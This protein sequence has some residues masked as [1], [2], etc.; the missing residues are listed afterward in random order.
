MR[1][2]SALVLVLAAACGDDGSPANPDAPTTEDAPPVDAD[3]SPRDITLRFAPKVGDAAFAC[4][5]SY[6]NLGAQ[7]T[8]VSPRDFRFYLHDVKL[9]SATGERVPVTLASNDWQHQGVALL[10]FEDFTGDCEDGTA[11]TNATVTGTAPDGTYTGISFTLG[12]PAALNHMDLTTLP[13]PLNV[14][15]LW[16]SWSSGHLFLAAATHTEITDPE[17]G[18]ND[19]YFHLGSLGCTGDPSMG[20]TVTCAKPNRPLIEVTGFDPLTTPIIAD[21][22]AL[23]PKSN[24]ATEVGC[25]SFTQAPCA[26]PF[27]FVGLNW[28]TGSQTPTTQ[29]LFRPGT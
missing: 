26:W 13:A 10:D 7:G 20:E 19:H 4:G 22:G 28:V 16:W 14:T 23:W 6:A 2:A 29:K 9:I 1:L 3:T 24:L 11:E 5:Q 12:I 18:T 17:P 8:T 27:D 15:G 25:H 21:W